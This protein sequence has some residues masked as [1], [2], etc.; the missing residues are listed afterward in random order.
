MIPTFIP[1]LVEPPSQPDVVVIGAGAA[2][3]SAARSCRAAGLATSVLEARPRVGGRAVTVSLMDH[4][5]DLGAHWL[6]AGARNPLVALARRGGERVRPSQKMSRQLFVD[7]HAATSDERAAYEAAWE[8][9]ERAYAGFSGPDCSF[10]DVVPPLGL[11]QKAVESTEILLS[12]R[13]LREVSFLDQPGD[14]LYADN[15][16]IDGGYG[17]YLARLAD[18]LP[19]TLNCQASSVDW[20]GETIAVAT[21]EGTIRAR[22]VIVAMPVSVLAAGGLRFSPG[23]PD[24]FAAAVHAFR[25]GTYEHVVLHWPNAPF[26]GAD[27]FASLIGGAHGAVGLLT[28]IDGSDLHYME[29]NH[30]MAEA[31]AGSGGG[32]G[33]FAMDALGAF[34]GKAEL[35]DCR[36][37]CATDWRAD[38][39]SLGGWG[40]LAPGAVE[41]RQVLT[42]PVADRIWFAGEALAG[43]QWGTVGGAWHHGERAAREVA[44]ALARR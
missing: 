24:K 32:G 29:L 3:I 30:D 23:L 10:A 6:H 37:L 33:R 26:S 5:V 12:G 19:I 35:A 2:G 21:D 43:P 18:G 25:I 42:Q 7:G 28:R 4:P 8:T 13:P 40:V 36:V 14:D 27:R 20:S 22:A 16:F 9:A 34:F 31:I 44:A 11:W 15:H 39:L 38:P 1:R 17:A 41:S